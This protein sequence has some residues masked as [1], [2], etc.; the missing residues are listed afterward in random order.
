ML[1]FFIK[2]TF[3]GLL[4]LI[5]AIMIVFFLFYLLPVNS[6][7]LTLGQRADIASVEAI[8]K[9]LR[10]NKPWYV[11]LV[12]YFNDVSPLS[13]HHPEDTESLTYLDPKKYSYNK[14]L[15]LGDELIFVAK[16]PYLGRSY[17]TRRPVTEILAEKIPPTA[18]LAFTSIV[19]ASIIGIFLGVIAA[20]N[21]NTFWDN[22]AVVGSV[23]GISQPSYFSAIVL[24]LI[25][26]FLLHDWT[27]LN[28]AGALFDLNDYGDEVIVWKNLILPAIALG[29]RPIAIITQLTRSSMLDVLSQD[30]IRT[31]RAK[32]LSRNKVL[33]K[34]SLRNA[35]NPVITSVSG[36]F[37]SLLAGSF[38]VEIIFDFKG[39]GYE[40]IKALQNFDFPVAMGAV[41]FIAFVFVVVNIF[42]DL[43]YGVLDP[44]IAV[45]S[46]T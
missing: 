34:H 8:E 17:Q 35:L 14:L 26:G 9:E 3:Y 32:G 23:I 7:R 20:I 42:V 5:G 10:L 44:R 29:I 36:W 16:T 37:A 13:F 21:H 24:A 43:L 46:K 11:R 2:R 27:G 40:T 15:S 39:L 18:I 1:S 41:L 33:F 19:F 30:Y 25:F 28:H 22:T 4:V 38:F 6:A 31:A 45:G 12:L